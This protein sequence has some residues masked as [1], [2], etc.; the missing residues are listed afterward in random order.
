MYSKKGPAVVAMNHRAVDESVSQLVKIDVPAAWATAYDDAQQDA[1]GS[2]TV[3]D[4]GSGV[5][6]K[7][8][9]TDASN[10]IA[11]PVLSNHTSNEFK[12]RVPFDDP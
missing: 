8:V 5:P 2:A 3:L 7:H 10:G 12:G 11:S 9:P 6:T 1:T 4:Y